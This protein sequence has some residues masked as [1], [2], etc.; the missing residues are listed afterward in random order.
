MADVRVVLRSDGDFQRAL[1]F[2][3]GL[4]SAAATFWTVSAVQQQQQQQQLRVPGSCTQLALAG[5]RMVLLSL[6]CSVAGRGWAALTL[7]VVDDQPH[8]TGR[9]WIVL[10]HV[11]VQF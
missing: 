5:R 11:P 10:L 9:L 7:R 6:R 1:R 4:P 3:Q 8:N 2:F